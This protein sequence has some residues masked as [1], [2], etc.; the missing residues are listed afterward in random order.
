VD[1]I[2][3]NN[4][5]NLPQGNNEQQNGNKDH[6]N[7]LTVVAQVFSLIGPGADPEKGAKNAIFS[8]KVA[9]DQ[10]SAVMEK[11]AGRR[12]EK[13]IEGFTEDMDKLLDRYA[14]FTREST[15]RKKAFEEAE[16]AKE[17][18]FTKEAQA[19]LA[20]V[21]DIGSYFGAYQKGLAALANVPAANNNQ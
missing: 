3:N 7:F 9:N 15:K 13:A 8:N 19:V 20:K 21:Q 11:L 16:L 10:V 6:K 18:E 17:K 5:D 12:Q 2:Q 14:E 4:N 1:N